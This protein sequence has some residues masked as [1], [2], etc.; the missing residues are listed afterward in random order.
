MPDL[1]PAP[2]HAKCAAAW[3]A[4]GCSCT[5]AEVGPHAGDGAVSHTTIPPP[6]VLLYIQNTVPLRVNE[7][8]VRLNERMTLP[9]SCR[10]ARRTRARS[11][12]SL[13]QW[14]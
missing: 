13:A 5:C 14:A 10:S 9:P 1:L 6:V 2:G 7:K 4:A 12:R 8:E 11:P 3:Y